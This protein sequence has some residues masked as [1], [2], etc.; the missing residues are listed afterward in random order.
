MRWDKMTE[1]VTV[2]ETERQPLTTLSPLLFLC[3]S[4]NFQ[5]KRFYI[6]VENGF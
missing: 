5:N 2:S 1:D 4:E 6:V 3:M